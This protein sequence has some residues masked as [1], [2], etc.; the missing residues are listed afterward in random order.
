MSGCNVI[1]NLNMKSSAVKEYLDPKLT[2]TF[3]SN[4]I[5]FL[6]QNEQE[7][8]TE[9]KKEGEH[10]VK[11]KEEHEVKTRSKSSLAGTRRYVEGSIVSLRKKRNDSSEMLR[12]DNKRLRDEYEQL[13]KELKLD[14]SISCSKEI[15]RPI[16]EC[17]NKLEYDIL[18]KEYE[19]VKQQ[20]KKKDE[21]YGKKLKLIEK[22][23]TVIREKEKELVEI[24]AKAQNK[25]IPRDVDSLYLE[26][27][28]NELLSL[29][30][31]YLHISNPKAMK[32]NEKKNYL[33]TLF[34]NLMNDKQN[35]EHK[36]KQL[37]HLHNELKENKGVNTR[38]MQELKEEN[39]KLR[40]QLKQI[41]D[42]YK[43]ILY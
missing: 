35:I 42:Q 16:S 23:I 40:G 38:T 32:P 14:E 37:L 36:F 29:G 33:K 19:N 13:K 17:I 15:N 22:E 2:A 31:D 9:R 28:L 5:H 25:L 24:N 18:Y 7:A 41:H 39:H 8:V 11:K 12:I 3:A 43:Y 6:P 1:A 10:E 26:S 21:F 34:D 27:I 30:K 4:N 20:L